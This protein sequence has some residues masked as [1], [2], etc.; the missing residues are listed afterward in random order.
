MPAS[1]RREQRRWVAAGSL[2][3][4]AALQ[5]GQAQAD[6]Q[7]PTPPWAFLSSEQTALAASLG[8]PAAFEALLPGGPTMRFVLIPPGPFKRGSWRH[9]DTPV[10]GVTIRRPYYLGIHE[11]TNRQFRAMVPGHPPP[12]DVEARAPS[13]W[14]EALA[15]PD[16]PAVWVSHADALRYA[17]WMTGQARVEWAR[18]REVSLRF[19]L[20]S[21]A[22]WER[23]ACAGRDGVRY[24]WGD[25]GEVSGRVPANLLDECGLARLGLE[26][27][28]ADNACP[29]DG[30]A[31]TSPVGGYAASA[32]GLYD[33]IGNVRE[34]CA[35]FYGLYGLGDRWDPTG[36]GESLALTLLEPPA[37]RGAIAYLDYQ[38]GPAELVPGRT[39]VTRGGSWACIL[40]DESCAAR[41]VLP[42]GRSDDRT[43]FRLV[44]SLPADLAAFPPTAAQAAQADA[45]VRWNLPSEFTNALGQRFLLVPDGEGTLGSNADEQSLVLQ[46][47]WHEVVKTH[48]DGAL[49][50]EDREEARRALG[51]EEARIRVQ[52]ARPYYLQSTEIVCRVPAW[53]VWEDG[54]L[55][56]LQAVGAGVYSR[57]HWNAMERPRFATAPAAHSARSGGD[58]VLGIQQLNNDTPAALHGAPAGVSYRLPFEVEWEYAC[59]AG[60]TTTYSFGDAVRLDQVLYRHST[61]QEGGSGGLQEPASWIVA[62]YP[63]NPFGL[64]DMHGGM[65]ELCADRYSEDMPPARMAQVLLMWDP[66]SPPALP[67][68]DGNMYFPA[69]RGGSWRS[70]PSELRSASRR[71]GPSAVS[72]IDPSWLIGARLAATV[73]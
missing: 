30:H 5:G 12:S 19:R 63:P 71:S 10:H 9:A 11:V 25:V 69:V 6:K 70:R 67:A 32:W 48:G 15:A 2:V 56:G 3:V 60:T 47:A 61:G 73:R 66:G 43:G 13:G 50:A 1:N 14:R 45:A 4:L 34:L 8:I 57:R 27:W 52:I 21:E 68:P 65:W 54:R 58:L 51:R 29:D 31:L 16:N 28:W 59:R 44:A 7:F 64:H 41:G 24:P 20:P 23:A 22:E 26:G 40:A 39:T 62:Q 37:V 46:E 33:M 18:S 35:D 38:R 53:G 17:E 42:Q 36:P 72:T 49:T 55:M